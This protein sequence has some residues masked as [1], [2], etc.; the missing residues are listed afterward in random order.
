MTEL[1]DA[2]AA[3]LRHHR[4]ENG[5]VT[6]CPVVRLEKLSV[7]ACLSLRV[8]VTAYL[9]I[10][11]E[12]DEERQLLKRMQSAASGKPV[13]PPP[14]P[15]PHPLQAVPLSAALW[16]AV[17]R[18]QGQ[19]PST[20]PASGNGF[21]AFTAESFFSLSRNVEHFTYFISHSWADDNSRKMHMLRFM[22]STAHI[23]SSLVVT[24][25][26]LA[27]AFTPVGYSIEQVFPAIRWWY[28]LIAPVVVL[29]V[30]LLWLFVSCV[31]SLLGGAHPS[32]S[33]A[34]W[35]LSSATAWIDKC[36]VD[37]DNV[38]GFLEGGLSNALLNADVMVVLIGP[39]YWTRLWCVYEI[40]TFCRANKE[41]LHRRLILLSLSWPSIA[42]PFKSAEPTDEELEPIRTFDCDSARC[43]K[44]SDRAAVMEAIRR[45]WQSQHS[46]NEWVR[47]ELPGIFAACK[48]Q[49]STLLLNY[50][51][52]KLGHVTGE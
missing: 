31:D 2:C 22:L 21:F 43:F 11:D 8:A 37:Q 34:P 7:D 27:L 17:W 52:E 45:E 4:L 38:R 19:T 14:P 3:L 51:T 9:P 1:S 47:S 24:C 49:Y 36:C 28:M 50:V 13:Q 5:A 23:G 32:H 42:N 48:R 16:P 18:K 20:A 35:A 30:G 40:A 29:I 39:T 44:P 15:P 25:S 33:Y 26:V 46:F 6:E 41:D 12:G 10:G